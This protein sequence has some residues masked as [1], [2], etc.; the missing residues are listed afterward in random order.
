MRLTSLILLL[1]LIGVGLQAFGEG[2]S[3][4]SGLR[5]TCWPNGNPREQATSSNGLREGSCQR[6]HTDGTPRAEGRY[7]AGR[8]VDEWRFYD[9]AGSLDTTRSGLFEAGA[10]VTSLGL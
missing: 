7:E 3:E 9:E 4:F 10:R 5:T 1:G 6:W 8:M 2:P